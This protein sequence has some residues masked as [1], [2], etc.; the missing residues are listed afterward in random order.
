MLSLTSDHWSQYP[1]IGVARQQ[2]AYLAGRCHLC[3]SHTLL[4]NR[5][6]IIS[7]SFL[8]SVIFLSC[9]CCCPVAEQAASSELSSYITSRGSSSSFLNW[10]N[11]H[12][13]SFPLTIMVR[14]V[15]LI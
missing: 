3:A 12:F 13:H 2:S 5:D 9:S 7:V 6:W 8:I 1:S 4:R 10:V 11:L 14:I 15:S